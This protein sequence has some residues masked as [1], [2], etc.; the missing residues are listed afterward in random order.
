MNQVN[1]VIPA[2]V[3][4]SIVEDYLNKQVLSARLRAKATSIGSTIE[5]PS[6]PQT[7][8]LALSVTFQTVDIGVTPKGSKA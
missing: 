2:G 1:I 3:V 4:A 6:E 5:S 8:G 7:P